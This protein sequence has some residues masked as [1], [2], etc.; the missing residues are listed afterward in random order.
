M[1]PWS[2]TKKSLLLA[3]LA[4]N[5]TLNAG[6]SGM[7]RN[8]DS[9]LQSTTQMVAANQPEQALQILEKNNPDKQKDLL[10]YL[11]KGELLRMSR[12]F[13]ASRACWMDADRVVRQWEETA[14]TDP[15]KLLGHLTSAVVNDKTR[16]YEGFDYEK[17]LLTAKIALDHIALGDWDAAR[18]EIK[19]THEREAIIAELHAKE[20][21][22]EEEEGK[23]RNISRDIKDLHGYPAETLN[24]PQVIALKNSYQNAFGHYLA[25]FVYEALGEPGL[26]A[27]GYRQAIELRPDVPFLEQGLKDLDTRINARTGKTDVLFVVESGLAP[28]RHS[29][30]IPLPIPTVGIVSISFPVIAKNPSASYNPA[31][32]TIGD[33]SSVGLSAVTSVDAMAR[34]ALRDEL[35]GILLRSAIRATL[36]GVTQKK[37]GDQNALLGLAVMVAGVVTES[38]D[39]RSWRTLPATIS[40]GRVAL[41]PGLHDLGVP[42]A[43]GKPLS[44]EVSGRHQVVHLRMVD[45]GIYLASTPGA[46]HG[47]LLPPADHGNKTQEASPGKSER[48]KNDSSKPTKEK[49]P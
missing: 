19:K 25:G 6:C 29:M 37:L 33:G 48:R 49:N 21:I 10:Y 16:P 17:V 1:S 3:A 32:L 28:G 14:K 46:S 26:A 4:L 40:L 41:K 5:A 9:E 30:M 23:K 22:Q 15:A 31:S 20:V 45:R 38:A 35:P 43:A 18:V 44:V 47:A 2:L 7:M 11:E 36:K 24:D 39:E 8:Y 34:R 42:G 13:S 27:P 12:D